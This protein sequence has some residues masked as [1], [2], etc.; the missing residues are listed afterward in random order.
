MP[1]TKGRRTDGP[2]ELDKRPVF[3]PYQHAIK[4]T[5]TEKGFVESSEYLK[6]YYSAID[7]EIYF[8]NEYVEEVCDIAWQVN[9]QTAPLYGYN[10]YTLDEFAQGS[11]IIQGSFSIRFISPNY[12]YEILKAAEEPSISHMSSYSVPTYSRDDLLPEGAVNT[13]LQY[14]FAE[15]NH[16]CLWPQTFDIDVVFGQK[17]NAG[18]VVHIVLENV[19]LTGCAISP[20]T[21]SPGDGNPPI[22][23]TYSFMAKD[24]K[25]IASA[26]DK[27]MNSDSLYKNTPQKKSDDHKDEYDPSADTHGGGGGKFGDDN[28]HG[29][30]G[31]KFDD[32][33]SSYGG[34]GG[35]F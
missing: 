15:D 28:T 30:G 1:E 7:A 35:K 5:K 13:G 11:R 12:L 8:G 6:R 25:T 26:P 4:R 24:I 2:K 22:T 10:S 16:H 14:D 17:S 31:G 21:S 27:P 23:E 34:G 19:K 9:Q 29:G 3:A 33:D 18:D 32:S 20:L